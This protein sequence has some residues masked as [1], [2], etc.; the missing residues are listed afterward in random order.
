MSFGERYE[1]PKFHATH[2]NRF[3][4]PKQAHDSSKTEIHFSTPFKFR[5]IDFLFL[6]GLPCFLPACSPCCSS[7]PPCSSKSS[8]S[9]CSPFSSSC[10]SSCCSSYSSQCKQPDVGATA[11]AQEYTC[12][13]AL[14]PRWTWRTLSGW[15]GTV[16]C[17]NC[18]KSG[19]WE[20]NR[21]PL[22]H[23]LPQCFVMKT[24][25]PSNAFV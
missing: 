18:K 21:A 8:W 1:P 4:D 7:C 23:L 10:C 12:S 15:M 13:K 25:L 22:P 24:A 14:Q 2:T 19:K 6:L 3:A 20:N 11:T 9:S 16:S 17:K 5:V